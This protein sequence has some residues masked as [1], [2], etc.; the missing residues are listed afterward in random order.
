MS[1]IQNHRPELPMTPLSEAHCNRNGYPATII[2]THLVFP[3]E[4]APG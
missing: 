4:K 3:V 1:A 2:V